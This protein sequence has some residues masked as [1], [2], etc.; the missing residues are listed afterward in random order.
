MEMAHP[1]PCAADSSSCGDRG[2]LRL[3]RSAVSA[4]E[5]GVSAA[6]AHALAK[7][8]HVIYFNPRVFL[9]A[10]CTWNERLTVRVGGELNTKSITE[11]KENE[12][13]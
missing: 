1:R 12:E 5:V 8:L 10:V 3:V 4:P 2:C 13:P 7:Q 6:A 9:T 11:K